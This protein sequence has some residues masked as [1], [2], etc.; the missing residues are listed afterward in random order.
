MDTSYSYIVWQKGERLFQC[1]LASTVAQWIGSRSFHIPITVKSPTGQNHL[2]VI[3][4][5]LL[6]AI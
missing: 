1:G 2:L 5:R 4:G 6:L 3:Q